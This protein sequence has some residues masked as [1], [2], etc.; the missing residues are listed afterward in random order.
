MNASELLRRAR[1][2]AGLSRSALAIRAGVPTS[3]VSRI[4]AGS[5]DPTITMLGRL[6]A[7]AGLTLTVALQDTTRSRQPRIEELADAHVPD[8][9][10][11]KINWT[12]LRGFIDQLTQ[13]QELT[14]PAIESPPHR[15]GDAMFDSLLAGIAEKLAD[16]AGI[17]RPRWTRA[18]PA[19]ATPWDTP[20][21]P[22][23]VKRAR[24]QTPPQL[25]ARN[26]WLAAHDLWRDAA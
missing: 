17:D 2:E 18:V 25:A 9:A 5:T 12:R 23:R 6:I 16:D 26:I 4:E 11:R 19:S 1:E 10:A 21:T 7:A 15:T 20:G 14:G 22:A 8:A 3:T 24:T 13:H